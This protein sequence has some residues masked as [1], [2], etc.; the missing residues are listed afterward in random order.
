MEPIQIKC[1]CCSEE[2]S[3][4][5][6]VPAEMV[7]FNC[8][9]CNASLLYIHGETLEVDEVQMEKFSNKSFESVD[10]YLNSSPAQIT[11]GSRNPKIIKARHLV[12][13]ELLD[14]VVTKNEI[15]DLIIDIETAS[16]VQEFIDKM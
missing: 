16:C 7:L 3:L 15:T 9:K 11:Q 10:A 2:A 5:L 8:H 13:E 14:H 12:G 1:P 4:S 6:D